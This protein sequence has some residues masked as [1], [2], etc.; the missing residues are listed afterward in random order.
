MNKV[1][2]FLAECDA[3]LDLITNRFSNKLDNKFFYISISFFLLLITLAVSKE[4]Y[5][6]PRFTAGV[7]SQD[8][9][10]LAAIMGEINERCLIKVVSKGRIKLDFLS[11]DLA[12]AVET[13]GL[14]LAHPE[15][16]DGPY[17]SST[18]RIQGKPYELLQT[19]DGLFVLPGEGVR[20]P[21]G[22]RM[23]KHVKVSSQSN[24]T[25][26]MTSGGKLFSY[27]CPLVGRVESSEVFITP[28]S[29]KPQNKAQEKVAPKDYKKINDTL[30]E[31][32]DALPFAAA[33]P[34]GLDVNF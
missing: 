23:G 15:Q 19:K 24:I 18:P 26:M 25:A 31:I 20:L 28:A 34:Q 6:K 8:V 27:G 29:E 2:K 14:I 12:P 9:Q 22:Y 11:S 3:R 17:V 4:V 16:W 32:A 10:R 1:D 33:N 7:I 13:S 5:N 21:N 30:R